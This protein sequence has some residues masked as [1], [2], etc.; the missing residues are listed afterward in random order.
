MS[1]KV[2]TKTRTGKT[3]RVSSRRSFTNRCTGRIVVNKNST[4]ANKQPGFDKDVDHLPR[5]VI[6]RQVERLM[7]KNK[8]A[9]DELSRL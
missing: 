2:R 9:L 4:V 1:K 7:K 8:Q 5:S 3:T 6:E